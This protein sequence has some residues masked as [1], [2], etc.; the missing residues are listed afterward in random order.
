MLR[1]PMPLQA[2]AHGPCE[3]GSER[4]MQPGH[5][6]VARIAARTNCCATGALTPVLTTT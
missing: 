3:K 6:P 1:S 2:G 5:T 4:F